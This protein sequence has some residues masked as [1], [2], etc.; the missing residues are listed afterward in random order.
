MIQ[1]TAR[2]VAIIAILAI[3][4]ISCAGKG[5]PSGSKGSI[6]TV[7]GSSALTQIS[8]FGTNP[9][10][11]SMYLYAPSS[12]SSNA[13]VVVVLHGCTQTAANMAD[14]GGW[15]DLANTYGFYVVYAQTSSSNNSSSCFNWFQSSDYTRGSGE[16]L[17]IKQMVDYVKSNYSVDSS[18]VFVSGFSAGGYMA[19]IMLAAYP[20]VFSAGAVMAGGPYGCGTSMVNAFT[21]MGGSTTKTA[22]AWAALLPSLPSGTTSYP[23]V[24]IFQGTSDYTVDDVNMTELMEQFTEANGVDQTSDYSSSIGSYVTYNE[25]QDA[26]G[27]VIVATYAISGM[28]HGI[29]VDVGTDEGQGG[30]TGSY[31]YDKDLFSSYH[32]IKF[33]GLLETTPAVTITA[34]QSGSTI[35]VSTDTGDSISYEIFQSVTSISSGVISSTDVSQ[36]TGTVSSGGTITLS[37]GSYKVVFTSN[38]TT[39][40]KVFGVNVTVPVAS[41]STSNSSEFSDTLTVSMSATTGT[42]YYSTDGTN[43]TQGSSVTISDTTTVY[44]IAIENGVASE[45]VSKTFTK[46]VS[47][48]DSATGTATEHYVA[49]RLSVSEYI[50]MGTKYGYIASF[51]LYQLSDGTWTDEI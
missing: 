50:A 10:S 7:I 19:T 38:G 48:V 17:S 5:T 47:Y 49:G 40:E 25:Y 23:R 9:G 1:K 37:D 34:T 6:Q 22:S 35:T 24:A 42:L 30:A 27:N 20:D 45:I 13:P 36:G 29:S 44:A 31:S 15:N 12:V 26:S 2:F 8:S 4:L 18:K 43:Y 28:S 11:L 39:L 14:L 3:T 21:C 16:A 51:T 32:A 46:A 33:F 41:I